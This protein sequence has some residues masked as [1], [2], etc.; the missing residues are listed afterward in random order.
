MASTMITKAARLA[1][2]PFTATWRGLKRGTNMQASTLM[3]PPD[4]YVPGEESPR[5]L[6]DIMFKGNVYYSGR[7]AHHATSVISTV[8][9]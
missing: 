1:M 9:S 4:I 3:A 2:T 7:L 6:G 8:K 5:I